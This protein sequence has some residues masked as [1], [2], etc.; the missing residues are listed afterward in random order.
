MVEDKWLATQAGSV[1]SELDRVSQG[2][3]GRVRELAD[4]YGTPLPQLVENVA[5]LEKNAAAH[6]EKMGLAV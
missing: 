6:L 5:A 1:Q 2:L 3:T 4:R